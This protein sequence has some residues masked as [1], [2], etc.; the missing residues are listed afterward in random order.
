MYILIFGLMVMR[1]FLT[2]SIWNAYLSSRDQLFRVVSHTALGRKRDIKPPQ[3][4]TMI[5]I[6]ST[7][8]RNG[9]G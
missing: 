6:F 9:A 1:G 5:A 2:P 7:K 4:K 3:S 8:C